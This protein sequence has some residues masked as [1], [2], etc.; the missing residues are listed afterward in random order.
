MALDYNKIA[1]EHKKDY[2]RKTDHLRF[3]KRLYS[4]KTHFIYELIQNAD[5]S[6]SRHL[7]LQLDVDALF[8]WN[9]GRQFDEK[10][11]RNI[12]S[13]GTSDKDLTQ[14]GNF[15]IGFKAV[16]NYTD[17]PEIYSNNE[18]FRIRDFTRPEGI[19]EVAP[20]VAEHINEGRTVFR[21]PF[22]KSLRQEE[23]IKRL[24]DRLSDLYHG[25][26]LLFLRHLERIAWK[27][28][29]N[30]Q[31][32][33]Y[34]CHR[35]PHDKIQNVSEIEL[36]V[37]MNGN[38]QSSETFLV[39]RKEVQPQQ[40]VIDE[41]LY[42]AEDEEEKQ[43]IRQSAGKSQ[44]IEV[45]FKLQ[46]GR[47]TVMDDDCVLF[48]YLP[49]Q[50]ETHL[51][52][53]IQA[54]YQTT[55]ARDN[56]PEPSENP[57]NRWLIQETA[58]FLPEVLEQLRD[59]G[60]LETTFFNVLP[61]EGEVENAFRPIAKALKKAMRERILVPT[62]DRGY[63][64]SENVFY[65]DSTS[66]RKLVRSSGMLS[67]SSLLHP[68]MRKDTKAFG[69]CFDVMDEAGVK[70]INASDL[71]CWLEKQS[72]DWFKNRTDAWMRSLYVYFN[73]KWSE[74]ELE[75]IK[76]I[77][78][79]RLENGEHVRVSDQLVYFPP[80][81]DKERQEI[82]PF[83]NEL[84][85]L[86][87]ALLE[88][89][90]HNEIKAF[91]VG[92]GVEV[93][94]PEN[95]INEL[96]C[97][98]YSQPN[99]LSIMKNRRHV[100]YIFKSWQKAAKSERS[101]LEESVS[102]IPI[103]RAYKGIQ[104]ETSDFVVPCN[105]Y[106]PQAYTGDDDLETYFSVSDGDLWFVDDKY[107]TNKSDT[108]VWLQ[109]LKAIGS[110]DTPLVIPKK[111]SRT[112]ENYQEFEEELTKR[113]IKSEY[114]TQWWVTN[115]VDLYLQG[116]SEA[117]DK[118]SLHGKVDF[119]RV[120]WQ[121]LVKMVNPLPTEVWKRNTF[122][123]NLFQGK[124][125][126]FYYSPK[127]KS[128]DA[129]FYR[130]L[131]STTW[132]PDEQ[133]NL[134]TPS[135]CFTST[136][137]N[138]KVLGDSVVYLPADFDISTEPAKWLAEK[139]D[140]HLEA[141]KE[142]VLNHLQKLRS[143]KEISIK[144]VEPLYRFL[145]AEAKDTQLH[146]K[147]KKEPLILTPNPEPRWWRSDEVFWEDESPVF[148][149][150]RGYLKAHYT[151]NLLKSFFTDHLGVSQN[152][153]ASDY[154]DGIQKVKLMKQTV[155]AKVS[156][157][158]K[159]LYARLWQ[160]LQ[161][162]DSG[163][164]SRQDAHL[165]KKFREESLIFAPNSE[166]CWWRTNQVFWGD[167]SPIFGNDR[168]YLRAY[169]PEM[170]KPFFTTLGVSES[171]APLDYV[172]GIR[173]IASVG[174]A[175]SSKVRKRIKLL[176]G[177]LWQL[178]QEDGT[179]QETEEWK[180]T[181]ESRCWLGKKGS[182]WE[183]FS[184]CELAW[185]DHNHIAE[186]FEGEVPFWGFDDLLGFAKSLE[187]EGCS[188]A[189]IEFHPGGD[190]EE[191]TVSSGE[192]RNLRPYIHAFLNSPRLCE[193]HEE[194]KSACDLDSLFVCLVEKLETVYTLKGISLSH[195]NPRESFL[196]VTNQ[197]VTLWLALKANADQSA[198]LIGDAL[199]DYFGNVKELSGF[200]EDLLTKN[201]ESVLTRWKQKGLQ[202]NIDALSP[203]EDSIEGKKGLT[204]S[205]DDKLSTNE[206]DSTNADNVI[207]ESDVAIPT[208]DED[209]DSVSDGVGESE[210]HLSS[211]EGNDSTADESE[212]ETPI[213]DKTP[214]VSKVDSDSPSGKAETHVDLLSH[215]KNISS[216]DTEVPTTTE[217]TRTQTSGSGSE[218][219]MPTVNEGSG[220]GNGGSNSK[221]IGSSTRTYNPLGTS[222]TRRS[223]GHSLS[224]SSNKG[225]RGGGHESSSGGG[226]SDEHR[227]LKER[228][229]ANTFEL[230]AEL[231][232][233]EVEHT[234][235]SG[236]RVD[237]LLKDSSESPVTVEVETGFSSGNGRYVGVWQAVKYQ[238]LAAMECGLECKQ[239]R[240]ILAA[241]EIP[242]DVK[243]KCKELGIEPIE[244]SNQA[245]DTDE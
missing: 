10:D 164:L 199:Q 72:F 191:D 125:S 153:T 22:K 74:P 5:D 202:T 123:S 209:N 51:K 108:E 146:E 100:R 28:E 230:G 36:T 172:H 179:W 152:A 148:D 119:S 16:Y 193:A 134:H 208:D 103:L 231:E 178:L 142:S 188:Q 26:S 34:T 61:L 225:S 159:T 92:I 48:A 35:H 166:R 198:W 17:L 85:I 165:R 11:V 99:K 78:L 139:L 79:V 184:R 80:D 7:E 49:T 245:G 173:E 27:G 228:L 194:G 221:R 196:D 3:Y 59:G 177:R 39:F 87:S 144:K 67:D 63:A 213:D 88:R 120:I 176:Y 214:E 111:I 110:M 19:D 84:P 93:L 141:D 207:G 77:P 71:L 9:D 149:N 243:K 97:P 15:G 65:P 220:I 156:E 8:L 14:I 219:G 60:L 64:K 167:A 203:E 151:E 240:S 135:E 210:V 114:T 90:D 206:F 38:N 12:C 163:F 76:K 21:L 185:N 143:D 58:D 226:E 127:S 169:Y 234:F 40:D 195:P 121:L 45:A 83:L 168:G 6:E 70:E 182:E 50:K 105:A 233:V 237:I 1:E 174:R 158:L 137:E 161:K 104:R 55:P 181:R 129:A 30:T 147:F 192:V 186:I 138:R 13:I 140:V 68:D 96:I 223:G 217:S 91:L 150:D 56:I 122:F 200:V 47:I 4:D 57:W 41:L 241:P 95:L 124:Y 216:S 190:Q 218:H 94:H 183:F 62:Q 109:F 238:H 31:I 197:K 187:I 189:K 232:L 201:K 107:L 242:D 106:L 211:S 115:I 82:E 204:T 54:R 42:Q 101:R 18:R 136:S 222:G 212:V 154:V 81:T 132:I 75:R 145:R 24:K 130:Q 180:Q 133:G 66:L 32:G 224:T 170:L 244:V 235:G 162:N 118:I 102:E 69:R 53:L 239:V 29:H 37:S 126:W 112:S 44:P 227:E 73:R 52:F 229:A 155:D 113:N 117:L 157:R 128:F 2:G 46:D 89:K 131:K 236:D 98:L 23:E 33:S 160:S 86:Q 116:L 171:A 175:D 215:T 205:V 20:R 43:R 25:R